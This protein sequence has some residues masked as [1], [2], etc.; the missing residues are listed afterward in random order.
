MPINTDKYSILIERN[1][2]NRGV[3]NWVGNEEDFKKFVAFELTVGEIGFEH[4]DIQEVTAEAMSNRK[5][6]NKSTVRKFWA[7]L[8]ASK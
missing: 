5:E 2:G 4:R 3:G 7:L 6:K 8:V 1:G